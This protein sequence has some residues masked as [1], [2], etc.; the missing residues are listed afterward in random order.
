MSM[1]SDFTRIF[2][3]WKSGIKASGVPVCWLIIDGHLEE[4]FHRQNIA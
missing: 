2:P 1:E 3:T 4:M